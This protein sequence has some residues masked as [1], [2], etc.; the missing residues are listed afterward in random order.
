MKPFN[1]NVKRITRLYYWLARVICDF[2]CGVI[3]SLVLME[4]LN[5]D[6]RLLTAIFCFTAAFHVPYIVLLTIKRFH[7]AGK[8]TGYAILCLLLSPFMPGQVMILLVAVQGSDHENKWGPNEE[9]L[10]YEREKEY[11]AR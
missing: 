4:Q 5:Q 7:D 1:R 9:A 2:L 11:Y 8:S 6:P 10:N 3:Y